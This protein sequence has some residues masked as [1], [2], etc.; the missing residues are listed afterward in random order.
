MFRQFPILSTDRTSSLNIQTNTNKIIQQNKNIHGRNLYGIRMSHLFINLFQILYFFKFILCDL[1]FPSSQSTGMF[2][3]YAG[4]TLPLGI[5]LNNS[6]ASLCNS[7]FIN[8]TNLVEIYN[9]NLRPQTSYVQCFSGCSALKKIELIKVNSLTTFTN[10]FTNCEALTD[11]KISGTITKDISFQSSPLNVE[12]MKN[13]ISNL[14]TYAGTS[15]EAKYTLTFTTACW[16]TLEASGK[17]FDDGLTTDETLTWANYV[18]VNK[19][20]NI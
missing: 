13:I 19:G 4:K 9:L 11:I 6:G 15:N 16:T 12:S 3:K 10:A 14:K 8:S 7:L 17:P 1:F 5:N 20:W 2:E 18:S